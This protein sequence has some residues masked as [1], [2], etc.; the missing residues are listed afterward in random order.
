MRAQEGSLPGRPLSAGTGG[1]VKSPASERASERPCPSRPDRAGLAGPPDLLRGWGRSRRPGGVAAWAPPPARAGP[2]RCRGGRGAPG[3]GAGPRRGGKRNFAGGG[4]RGPRRGRRGGGAG[5]GGRR[6][7]GVCGK[8][9]APG[10]LPCGL[11][12]GLEPPGSRRARPRRP[13]SWDPAPAARSGCW[14]ARI[15][16]RKLWARKT[17]RGLG[18]GS[19]L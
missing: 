16:A 9:G 13:G 2:G 12:L 10:R 6:H 3:G 17:L 18:V 14:G 4:S 11:A 7:V 5:G 19:T 1:A 15:R 8:R